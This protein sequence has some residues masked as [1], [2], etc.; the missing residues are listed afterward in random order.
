MAAD[1]AFIAA[2]RAD[3]AAA[4]DPARAPAMQAYMKSAMPYLGIA[5]PLRRQ[6]VTERV[7]TQ[8]LPDTPTLAATM[9]ALWRSASHRE[10]RYAAAELARLG[11]HKKLADVRLLPVY[12]E[13]VSSGAWWDY[14]DDISG[15]GIG[16]LLL[17]DPATVK[18]VLRHWA[19]GGDLWLRRA[20]ILSQRRLKTGFDAQL[21][22]D[23]I[24]PSIGS[25]RFAGEFFIRKGIGWALRE[26]SYRAPDEVIAF[27][28]EYAAQLSP[29]TQREALKI[30]AR[31]TSSAAPANVSP[32]A[33]PAAPPAP[34]HAPAR[35]R[36]TA[37]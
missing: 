25:G 11:R 6:L 22:Y 17:L 5:A 20:A 18:P 24:L 23:T 10:E 19:V 15:D 30:I 1:A 2:L 32:A 29:L 9:L 26:R 34:A 35:R 13:M 8:P 7:K 21:L 37:R 28:D 33:A 3:L 14:C 27:C 4:A 31:R 12:E 16:A 36:A